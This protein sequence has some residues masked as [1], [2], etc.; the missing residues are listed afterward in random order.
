LLRQPVYLP[1]NESLSQRTLTKTL[2]TERYLGQ[3]QASGP[4]VLAAG[5]GISPFG[6]G[7][8]YDE[9]RRQKSNI[10]NFAKF[11]AVKLF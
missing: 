11:A 3:T 4:D 9:M 7:H 5:W 6:W 2:F 1:N 8:S 10:P